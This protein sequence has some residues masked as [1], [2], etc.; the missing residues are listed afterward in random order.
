VNVITMIGRVG[1]DAELR[2]T[3]TGKMMTSFNVALDAGYGDKKT[4]TWMRCTLWGDRAEKLAPYITKGSQIGVTGEFS[5]SEWEKDGVKRI[6]CEVNVREV[7]L[8]GG[9]Q[10]HSEP[11]SAVP[12]KTEQRSE[13]FADDDIP[14]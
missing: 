13:N 4:T 5:T 10:D 14:F 7:T 6:S 8:L 3:K 11:E 12:V 9:K 1:A 2:A